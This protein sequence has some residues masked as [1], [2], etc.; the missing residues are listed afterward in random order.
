ME[1]RHCVSH[2]CDDRPSDPARGGEMYHRGDI[3]S[4]SLAATDLFIDFFIYQ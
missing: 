4:T 2:F 3:V 1:A